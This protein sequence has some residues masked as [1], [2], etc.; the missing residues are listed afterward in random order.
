MTQPADPNSL[1]ETLEEFAAM[2]KT[3]ACASC[4][5]DTRLYFLDD[6]RGECP[7][8]RYGSTDGDTGGGA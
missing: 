1:P 7:G 4:G 8:C 5:E 2:A 3:Q 6:E